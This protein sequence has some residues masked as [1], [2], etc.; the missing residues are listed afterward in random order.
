MLYVSFD[1]IF[2][3]CSHASVYVCAYLCACLCVCAYVWLNRSPANIQSVLLS[4]FWL[5]LIHSTS[6]PTCR[7]KATSKLIS[8]AINNNFDPNTV[9]YSHMF[10]K[11]KKKI[12]QKF[13]LWRYRRDIVC[14][15]F[16]RLNIWSLTQCLICDSWICHSVKLTF[17]YIY[18]F[19]YYLY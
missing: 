11:L 2:I 14:E 4:L 13:L 10:L 5:R 1:I 17:A 12:L 18:R 16:L 8:Q 3:F 6:A 9:L 7:S 15:H 19:Q